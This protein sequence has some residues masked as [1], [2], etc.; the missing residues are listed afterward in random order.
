MRSTRR[1]NIHPLM[2]GLSFKKNQKI[3]VSPSKLRNALQND[4]ISD[5][6]PSQ[7]QD[8]FLTF[9]Y[10]QGDRFKA[11][12]IRHISETVY[13]VLNLNGN[14]YAHTNKSVF[15][16][17]N[18]GV[19]L[20]SNV[21][22][23]NPYTAVRGIADLLVRSDYLNKLVPET[24]TQEQA[25]MPA[26][27]F[28]NKQDRTPYHYVVVEIKFCTL[29]LNKKLEVIPSTNIFLMAQA[30]L[31][32]RAMY[33]LQGCET[34]M[35]VLARKY[36]FAATKTSVHDCMCCFGRISSV[37][38]SIVQK[39]KKAI[40][41]V[42]KLQSPDASKKQKYI[43]FLKRDAPLNMSYQ[44]STLAPEKVKLALER[45]ELTLISNVGEKERKCAFEKGITSFMDPRCSAETLG[46]CD[47]E[48]AKYIN[49]IIEVNRNPDVVYLP[50]NYKIEYDRKHKNI[51]LDF[52]TVGDVFFCDFDNFPKIKTSTFIFLAG[53]IVDGEYKSFRLKELTLEAEEKLLIEIVKFMNS[54]GRKAT[55]WYWYA[56]MHFLNAAFDRH[57]RLRQK[58]DILPEFVDMFQTLKEDGFAVKGCFRYGLKNV[59]KAMAKQSL[60]N[61]DV[62]SECQDGMTASLNA[63]KYYKDGK[64]DEKIMSDIIRYNYYDCYAMEQILKFL[65]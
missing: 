10:E 47:P 12:A 46:I 21:P 61:V 56:E 54:F 30:A 25:C 19:P 52:E 43:D 53:F 14:F 57:P 65:S 42:R 2:N 34:T 48:K 17:M 5:C 49:A 58:L 24:Y 50:Q 41:H 45:S 63:W 26:P 51:F 40:E 7:Q 18:H 9:L 33:H 62:D 38:Y 27:K 8:S 16:L 3:W 23:R 36:D 60:I 55:V 39:T 28:R 13:P 32:N 64:K 22:L 59:T 15:E 20:M 37:P 4:L 44:A 31:L 1:N 29:S 6:F 11:R 35:F